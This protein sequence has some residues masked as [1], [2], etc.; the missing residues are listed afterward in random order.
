MKHNFSYK[1][2]SIALLGV[3]IIF[4]N[5]EQKGRSLGSGNNIITLADSVLWQNVGKQVENILGNEQYTPQ[6][7]PVFFLS[8]NKPESIGKFKRF[9]QILLVGTLDQQGQTQNLLD[10]LLPPGSRGRQMVEN[11]ERFFFPV[12]NPWSRDQLLVV[13]VSRDLETLQKHLADKPDD[14]F[15]T[16]DTHANERATQQ[17]YYTHE[18]KNLE[19]HFFQNYGWS[20][21][22]PNEY[23]IS[24]DSGKTGFVWLRRVGPKSLLRDMFI[25]REKIT[26]PSV[27]SKEWIIS[28]R[29][30]LTNRYYQGDYIYSDSLITVREKLIN[31]NNRYAIQVEGVWQN[32]K[33]MIGGPFRS[34]AFYNEGDDYIYILDGS[35]WAP[36]QRKWP[37]LRQLD[38]ILHTFKTV[39]EPAIQE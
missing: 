10:Q 33:L 2:L 7:E 35:V 5:C 16:F 34:I 20:I 11:D 8:L 6:P 26:D 37:Y 9:P 15:N 29:D 18:Q 24:A 31:F 30:S 36:E 19:H 23:F 21:R 14:L 13:L 12:Q 3:L 1:A 17:I 22:V 27:L 38:I 25:Y 28:K 39:N 32:E 4:S